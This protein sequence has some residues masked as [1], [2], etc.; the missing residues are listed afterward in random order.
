MEHCKGGEGANVFDAQQALEDWVENGKA[1][2]A[3]VATKFVND[4]REDGIAFSRPLCP[5]PSQARFSGT[6]DP[7]DAASFACKP[8]PRYARPLVSPAYLR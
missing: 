3:I 5:Y 2:A 4:K 7:N 8:G 1:P 6:G